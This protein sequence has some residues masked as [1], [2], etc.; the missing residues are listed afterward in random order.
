MK[1]FRKTGKIKAEARE[2]G[3]EKK[4][5]PTSTIFAFII[6]VLMV[7]SGVGYMWEGGNAV[8]YNDFKFTEKGD[9]IVTKVDGNEVA[10]S[11]L[12]VDSH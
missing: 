10:F 4:K 1:K 6:I 7:A 2:S 12:P 9:K 5:T 11:T 3:P 8:F